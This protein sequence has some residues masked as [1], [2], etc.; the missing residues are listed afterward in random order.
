VT[1]ARDSQRLKQSL[2]IAVTDEGMQIDESDEQSLNAL[3]SM[4]ES[5]EFGSNVTLDS[6][7]Q[8]WKQHFAICVTDDRMEIERNNKHD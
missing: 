3:L 6:A 4:T 1:V 8:C 5:A 7:R 2:P